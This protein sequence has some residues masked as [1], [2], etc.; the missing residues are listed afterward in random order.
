MLNTIK[1]SIN[2]MWKKYNSSISYISAFLIALISIIGSEYNTLF[3]VTIMI[4]VLMV[5]LFICFNYFI[6]FKFK[7]IKLSNQEFIF[8]PQL[9]QG[10]GR[11]SS[12]VLLFNPKYKS[13]YKFSLK[14]LN[15]AYNDLKNWGKYVLIL[16]KPRKTFEIIPT[17]TQASLNPI[18]H[19]NDKYCFLE[20]EFEEGGKKELNFSFEIGSNED[21]KGKYCFCIYLIEKVDYKNIFDDDFDEKFKEKRIHEV[22][23]HRIKITSKPNSHDITNRLDKILEEYQNKKFD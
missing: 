16:E 6:W 8:N 1:I 17:E 14:L 15:S 21:A 13:H 11:F 3:V 4:Y 9:N 22:K 10:M 18:I 19:Y 7:P 20:Q 12:P 23:A 5:F 2:E